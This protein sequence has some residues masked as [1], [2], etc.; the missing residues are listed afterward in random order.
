[1]IDANIT[2]ERALQA[3]KEPFGFVQG[4]ELEKQTPNVLAYAANQVWALNAN[5]ERLIAILERA[6]S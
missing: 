1:M 6:K 4:I 2:R 3:L 5:V